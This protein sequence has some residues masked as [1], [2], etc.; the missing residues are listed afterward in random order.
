MLLDSVLKTIKQDNLLENT[1]KAGDVSDKKRDPPTY[2]ISP[3]FL[4][5]ATSNIHAFLN[6]PRCCSAASAPWRRSTRGCSTPPAAW[7]PS[8]P[9]TQT[10]L[11][12]DRICVSKIFAK[13]LVWKTKVRVLCLDIPFR[14][15]L[16]FVISGVTR[17]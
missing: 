5:A 14:L 4:A 6:R 2:S 7:G 13:L 9:L 10:P 3:P 17:S 11:P 12:G 15:M 16:F 1:R 8:A